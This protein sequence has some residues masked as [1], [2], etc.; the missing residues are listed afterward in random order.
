MIYILV[1]KRNDKNIFLN[2]CY[3]E[4]TTIV[5]HHRSLTVILTEPWH[6]RS[7]ENSNFQNGKLVTFVDSTIND[8]RSFKC[9][10]R[11]SQTRPWDDWHINVILAYDEIVTILTLEINHMDQFFLSFCLL[12]FLFWHFI[13]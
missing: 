1:N 9:L 6:R 4:T 11:S 8:R 7:G 12:M 3:V 10:I 2:I 5:Y 13:S